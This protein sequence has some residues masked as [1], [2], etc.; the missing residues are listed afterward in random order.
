MKKEVIITFETITP[1]WTGDAWQECKEIRPS[2]L[3]GSLRFW[4]EVICYFSGICKKEDFNSKNGRFEK[5]VDR[6]KF[7][8]CLKK[9]CLKKK[10]DTFE[11]KIECLLEQGIPLPSIIFG[12]TNWKSLMEVE[13]IKYLGNYYFGNK[14][15]LPYAIGIKK[16]S[17][18]EPLIF[19]TEEE[20]REKINS[21]N[22][23]NFR[24]KLNKAK[25]EWSFFFFPNLYFY[26]K[27][28]VK[29]QIEEKILEPIF[30]PLLN[31]MDKYGF[32]GGK[33]N[34]GYGRLKIM[35]N[36][37][38]KKDDFELFKLSDNISSWKK[39][40]KIETVE[41]DLD[42]NSLEA[43]EFLKSILDKSSDDKFSFSCKEEEDFRNKMRSFPEKIIILENSQGGSNDYSSIIKNLLKTKVRIRNC[44]RHKCENQFE[45]CFEE[46]NGEKVKVFN[47]E[48]TLDCNNKGKEITCEELK[49]WRTF[50]HKLLGEQGEGSKILPFIYKEQQEQEQQ[51]QQQLKGGLLSIAGLLN[52]EGRENE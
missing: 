39:K 23:K 11:T 8:E 13:S 28:E 10:G 46:H 1:L 3:I 51:E 31:F 9:K 5:E 44:L 24:D 6:R 47:G 29:F 20:W 16:N 45:T 4:F 19:Q 43:S 14:L 33:W 37:G 27:F 32:W 2:S 18:E 40:M 26:G 7:E 21:Y 25:K 41:L 34:I 49:L 12:T 30:F 22:G 42:F 15:N 52:L 17:N 48:K 35:V 36:D 38:W 50:R